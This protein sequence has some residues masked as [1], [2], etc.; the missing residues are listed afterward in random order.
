MQLNI[1]PSSVKTKIE[2]KKKT[3]VSTK[4]NSAKSPLA[5]RRKC[6]DCATLTLKLGRHLSF[7]FRQQVSYL[8]FIEERERQLGILFQVGQ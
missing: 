3:A 4:N 1:F 7:I 8:S 6:G 5:P 2:N